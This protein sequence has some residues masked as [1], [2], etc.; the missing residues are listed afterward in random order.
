MGLLCFVLDLSSF[1]PS[2]LKDL[3]QY[4][5]EL[6]NLYALSKESREEIHKYSCSA[7]A[8]CCIQKNKVSGSN[9]LRIAYHP[10][11]NFNLRDFHHAVNSLSADHLL[12]RSKAFE[13]SQSHQQVSC[14]STLLTS[15]GGLYS[16]GTETIGRKV[17]MISSFF[18][19]NAVTFRKT[20]MDAAD[21]C[22]TIE[23]IQIECEVHTKVQWGSFSE[24]MLL[25]KV[26]DFTNSISDFKNCL[27]HRVQRDHWSFCSLVKRWFQDIKDELREPVQAVLVFKDNLVE[28]RNKIF[29]NLFPAIM[30]IED[31]F[32]PCQTCR[33]HGAYTD[34]ANAVKEGN[35][36]SVC[37]ITGQ[38][39][40]NYDLTEN[41]LKIGLETI[42]LLPS[43]KKI[44]RLEPVST[45]VA[46]NIIQCV[47]L[48]SLSEDLFFGSSFIILA[49]SNH[50]TTEGDKTKTNHQTFLGLCQALDSMDCGLI[51]ASS[52][53]V[54]CKFESTIPCFYLLQ[55]TST[56]KVLLRRIATSEEYL[57]I[58]DSVEAMY[59][60]VPE[61]FIASINSSLTKMGFQDYNPLNQERGCHTK[62]NWLVKE[63]LQFRSVA[64]PTPNPQEN[65]SINSQNLP[66]DN[67][68]S[69]PIQSPN[70]DG[71]QN[72]DISKYRA[73]QGNLQPDKMGKERHEKMNMSPGL[74]A[75]G[76]I[77]SILERIEPLRTFNKLNMSSTVSL[78]EAVNQSTPRTPHTQAC[79]VSQK[80]KALMG[81]KKPLLPF[82]PS[83]LPRPSFSPNP[84]P[85][86]KPNF[87]RIKRSK[88]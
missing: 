20:V 41:G 87:R 45:T 4:L 66:I 65:L 43:F 48:A 58:P 31:K 73:D 56:A 18:M 49:S 83:Q 17:I 78:L 7:I 42:L 74:L 36:K 10:Q 6:A 11:E 50:L 22:V 59:T 37:P 85:Q 34:T 69:V 16:W 8:L 62:L 38:E 77:P 12:P 67:H 52:C 2:L 47:R 46:F 21:H 29:C 60:A 39:L 30:H 44:P 79:S 23:F 57:P 86:L 1:Q 5:L 84:N 64:L 61:E 71:E 32:R 9:E 33:C 88:N 14:L 51:C 28:S 15:N 13:F 81:M 54:E 80:S 35:K 70:P 63:S 24:S 40:D 3:K 27:F 72:L 55:P 19:E 53:D 25:E 82:Q 68:K 26:K 76:Q 75:K